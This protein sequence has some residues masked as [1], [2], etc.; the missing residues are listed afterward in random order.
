VGIA[1]SATKQFKK[2]PGM[3][4]T[5]L[6]IIY[7]PCMTM[8]RHDGELIGGPFSIKEG[9]DDLPTPVSRPKLIG[10]LYE[11]ATSLGI[12]VTF[13][14]RVLDY[15]EILEANKAGAVTEQGERFEAD[16][17]IAA[18]GVGSLSWKAVSGEVNKPKSSGFSVYRVAYST[19][20]AFEN[21]SVK[22]TFALQDDGDDVCHLFLG[23]NTHGIVLVSPDIT[24]WMLTHKVRPGFISSRT[25]QDAH[26]H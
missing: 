11:Y 19:K 5:Y 18:D 12:S 3:M 2:W 21:P 1:P 20:T 17:V 24:T 8:F 14:K 25:S 13:G 7:R 16:L 23:K 10:A 9:A 22:K 26:L 6:D 4:E 15:Y